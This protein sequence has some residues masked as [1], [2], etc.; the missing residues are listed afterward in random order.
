M[1]LFNLGMQTE[2]NQFFSLE[3]ARKSII[4]RI[5]RAERNIPS[6]GK[7]PYG[8]TFDK[9]TEKWG[10]DIQK[11][12]WIKWASEQ[13]LK[14]E[15]LQKIADKL[16]MNMP[17]LWKILT[18]RSGTEWEVSFESKKNNI[19]ETRTIIIPELLP[20]KTIDL[21]KK[22]AAH[23][24]K[25]T[26]GITV[27]KY[28]L[29]GMVKCSSCGYGM[30][31]QT[32]HQ[33]HRYYRHAR[34]RKNKCTTDNLW[35]RADDIENAVLVQ[36]FA[37]YG[38]TA[39][40]EKAISKAIPNLKEV[41]SLRKEK[42]NYE[43][44]L[45]GLEKEIRRIVKSIRNDIISDED[46]K[47]DREDIKKREEFLKNEIEKIDYETEN[48]PTEMQIMGDANFIKMMIKRTFNTYV[49]LP[50][51]TFEDR[52]KLMERVFSGNTIDEQ[53]K[54]GVFVEKDS[55]GVCRYQINGAITKDISGSLPMSRDEVE[56]I[57][58]L[59]PEHDSD[60]DPFAERPK[61]AKGKTKS[62][63][64]KDKNV[65]RNSLSIDKNKALHDATVS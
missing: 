20:Q 46:A 31:G 54:L 16:E 42:A 12:E 24:K 34:H 56:E 23:N 13:Y 28:L 7:L 39:G 4:N 11:Q 19:K 33:K 14:G 65:K 60:F 37:M 38:D 49:N 15:S 22:R 50:S 1:D 3:Q 64:L 17:N 40:I 35:I 43:K 53:K 55:K 8:R 61:K 27:N 57:L 41:Q 58:H 47:K 2:M 48:I 45:K 62:K 9:A 44:K 36:L 18:K 6:T 32:N 63:N 5:A 52:R 26:H 30:F 21:I 10:L 25:Y 29:S 59:D 51:M